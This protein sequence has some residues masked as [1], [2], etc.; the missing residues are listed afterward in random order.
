MARDGAGNGLA[1]P[2]KT[3]RVNKAET[4]QVKVPPAVTEERALGGSGSKPGRMAVDGRLVI[5]CPAP[6]HPVI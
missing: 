3:E 2:V 5:A 1:R 4:Y 6:K